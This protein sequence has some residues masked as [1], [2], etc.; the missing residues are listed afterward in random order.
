MLVLSRKPGESLRVGD[1]IRITVVST[2]PGQVRIGISA[3][4]DVVIH[5]EEVYERIVQANVEAAKSSAEVPKNVLPP[6]KPKAG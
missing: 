4:N 5:R 6:N 2:A 3:P 1:D